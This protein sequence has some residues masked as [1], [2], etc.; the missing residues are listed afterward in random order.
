MSGFGSALRRLRNERGLSLRG[1]SMLVNYDFGY[2]GQLERGERSPTSKVANACDKAL[3]ANGIL[4]DEYERA[5]L[6]DGMQRRTVL[7]ALSALAVGTGPPLVGLE[8]LRQGLGHAVDG[9]DHDEWQQIALDYGRAYYLT[10]PDVLMEQV[11]ADL[12]VLQAVMAESSSRQKTGLLRAAA[13][14]SVIVAMTLT[15]TGRLHMARRWWSTARRAA[16]ESRCVDTQVLAR[17]WDVTNGCYDGRPLSQV[18]ERS[19]EAIALAG[20]RASA[21]SAGLY[22]GRAQA[23]ALAGRHDE[24]LTAVRQ[25]AEITARLPSEITNDA[26]SLWAWPEHRLRHTESYVATHTGNLADADAAQDRALVLYPECQARLRTQVSLHRAS[27]LIQKGHVGEGLRFA[28]DLLDE[29]PVEQ[30]NKLLY[31]VARHVMAVVPTAER[32]R[33]ELGDL[34]ARLPITSIA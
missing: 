30:H 27:C 1:L 11:T 19:D 20:N 24:A 12:A 21:G 5:A 9:E 6:D 7:R 4:I 33:I 25:V 13:Q 34:A 18:I 10:P 16:D 23:L 22:A 29:L 3:D 15:A 32:R 8:A 2:L 26:A 17:A 31:E 28:A 14:L